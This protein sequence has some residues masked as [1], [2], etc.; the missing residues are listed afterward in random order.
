[1][2][3]DQRLLKIFKLG[4]QS[5]NI[6]LITE[7]IDYIALEAIVE[8]LPLLL[9]FKKRSEVPF[10]VDYSSKVID[11]LESSELNIRSTIPYREEETTKVIDHKDEL[12]L[13]WESALKE[14]PK[15]KKEE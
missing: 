7:I 9:D 8:A 5:D 13:R 4:L 14:V 1:M 2:T 6:E 12:I 11:S 3:K 10:L 15:D